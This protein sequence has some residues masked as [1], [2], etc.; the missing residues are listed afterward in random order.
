MATVVVVVVV[1]LSPSSS[2][3]TFAITIKHMN[4]EK[5]ASIMAISATSVPSVT[6]INILLG[7]TVVVSS[8]FCG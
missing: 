8:V 5:H 3:S 6:K 1:V 7:C 4:R 2:G